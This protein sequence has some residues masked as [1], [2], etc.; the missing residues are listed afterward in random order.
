M[1]KSWREVVLCSTLA[2]VVSSCASGSD[3]GGPGP[4]IVPVDPAMSTLS[5]SATTLTADGVAT[6]VLIVQ[7]RS[8]S[9]ANLNVAGLPVDITRTSGTGTIGAVSFDATSG[10]YRATVTAPAIMQPLANGTGAFAATIAGTPVR[11]GALTATAVT[12]TYTAVANPVTTASVATAA[13]VGASPIAAGGANDVYDLMAS[14]GDSWRIS[15]AKTGSAFTL[16][17]LSTQYGLTNASGTFTKATSTDG[18]VTTYTSTTAGATFQLDVDARTQSVAGGVTLSTRTSAV[19]GTGYKSGALSALAGDYTY[20]SFTT[21]TAGAATTMGSLRISAAGVLTICTAGFVADATTCSLFAGGQA[22]ALSGFTTSVL[23]NGLIHKSRNG[24]DFGDLTVQAGD[25]GVVLMIDRYGPDPVQ[26]ALQ[27]R[28]MGIGVPQTALAGTEANGTWECFADGTRVRR[29]VVNGT[30]I[31]TSAINGS[32]ASSETLQYN[33]VATGLN[34]T[35]TVNGVMNSR[36]AVPGDQTTNAY[37]IPASA[38]SL[39]VGGQGFPPGLA[40]ICSR[41]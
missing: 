31:T 36:Y 17:V 32:D 10:T 40:F 26:P 13:R 38:A 35:V 4:A 39:I 8:A 1:L 24:N 22:A 9:G 33:R 28:G 18:V 29:A 19:A 14:I 11:G 16:Q 7:P 21:G 2:L 41:R 15:L 20:A 25:R 6:Q 27:S 37:V 30:Q 34:T 23:S 5:S 12:L 3:D